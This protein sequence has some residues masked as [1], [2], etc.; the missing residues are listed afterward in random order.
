[1]TM[2][3]DGP[4]R[5]ETAFDVAAPLDQ[6]WQHVLDVATLAACVPRFE[7]RSPAANGVH[8]G[9]LTISHNGVGVRGV[10]RLRAID[11]DLDQRTASVAIEG[12]ELSGPAIATGLLTAT[13][14]EGAGVSRVVLSAEVDLAGH[15]ASTDT[16]LADAQQLFH[17]FAGALGRRMVEPPRAG[18]WHQPATSSS[19]VPASTPPPD[20]PSVPEEPE[21]LDL[22]SVLGERLFVRYAPVGV[23]L[24][25]IGM[26]AWMALRSPRR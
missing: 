14:A 2:D 1:M 24:V 19:S 13:V 6:S 12:R 10:G 21:V 17:E 11:A 7:A 22:G 3:Y 5:L 25:C 9:E 4:M 8:A 16:V 15:R 18:D 23:S 26:L 20:E